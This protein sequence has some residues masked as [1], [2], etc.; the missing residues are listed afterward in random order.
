MSQ[1]NPVPDWQQVKDLF[2]AAADLDSDEQTSFLD[3]H[4]RND[5]DLRRAVEDLL[6]ADAG[7]PTLLEHSPL[8][9]VKNDFDFQSA[10]RDEHIGPYKIL[11][12]LGSG[13]MGTVYEAVRDDAEF[14]QRVALKL[15]RLGWHTD[16]NL[17]QRFHNERQILAGLNH[18]NIALLLDGGTTADGRPYF[19]MEYVEGQPLNEYGD[20]ANLSTTERLRLF[21]IVCDA[22]QYA[23]GN[24]V[25]HRDI[26]PSNIVVT[27]D[28]VV[29]LLDFGIAKLLTPETDALQTATQMN[30]M[31]PAYASPEQVRGERVT[32]ASDVYSLGVVLYELL[33]GQRP[34]VVPTNRPDEMSRVIC[35]IEP[36]RPSIVTAR[37]SS[38]TASDTS[39]AASSPVRPQNF[40][41]RAAGNGATLHKQLRGDVDNIV[42][43]ALRKEPQRRYHSVEQFSEDIRRH[44][45]G[46]TVIA[47]PDTLRY[48]ATKLIQ[49]NKTLA[50]AFSLVML[51]LVGGL[52]LALWQ[53][54]IAK[55]QRAIAERR[56]E[57]AHQLA[58][59]FVFK[60][61][62]A[63]LNLPGSTPVRAMLVK[64]A[65]TYLD[66]LA[67]DAGDDATLKRELALAYLK[68]G[69]VQGQGVSANVGD[70]GGAIESCRKAVVL[71]ESL[72]NVKT[73]DAGARTQARDDLRKAYQSL[74]GIL[75]RGGDNRGALEWQKKSLALGEEIA[76]ADPAAAKKNL[77]LAYNYLLVGDLLLDERNLA[78]SAKYYRLALPLTEKLHAAEPDN[79]SYLHAVAAAYDR[80]ARNLIWTAD[81]AVELN[82]ANAET[83][84]AYREA[85]AGDRR[86]LEIFQKM[87]TMDNQNA[88]IRRGIV[89]AYENL[90]V[91]LRG[92]GD[93]DASTRA[94]EQ[95]LTL[96]KESIAADPANREAQADQADILKELG[97]T[98]AQSGKSR[99]SVLNYRAALSINAAIARADKQNSA[100][101]AA[102]TELDYL[103]GDALM[104]S[105]DFNGAMQQYRKACDDGD[106]LLA[107]FPTSSARILLARAYGKTANCHAALAARQPPLAPASRQ[108]WQEARDAYQQAIAVLKKDSVQTAGD[109][110]ALYQRGITTCDNAL[111]KTE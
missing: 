76:A 7:Q 31:T 92:A 16:Q 37:H 54:R 63:I 97:T 38:R 77:G 20:A 85:V 111:A 3:Q 83:N 21:R 40:E 89:A 106:K 49:R 58:D 80:L 25:V 82:G 56:F 96:S 64:D 6:R 39:N 2:H 19:A 108:H 28:G 67:A 9:A 47:R 99:E 51:A 81:A 78:E 87:A 34:Y 41:H 98:F 60:Y 1:P 11:R 91:A 100:A 15:I 13:G 50:V 46:L 103:L 110:T 79:L 44:L 45:E 88:V 61:H 94:I 23:H 75:A 10:V 90:G 29:K 107:A 74:G 62:D 5:A 8:I 73:N 35:E 109:Q 86:V 52:G 12:E 27:S 65:T 24:L 36:E 68:L 102:I 26:K 55:Q 101:R 14:R 93:T 33:T 42:L 57:D 17:R 84:A 22:V 105:N 43:R 30:L 95:A 69:N 53:A 66:R 104:T 71:Y 18:P 70:T 32:T 72:A 4:C 48:R 59:S